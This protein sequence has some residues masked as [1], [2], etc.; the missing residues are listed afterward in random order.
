MGDDNFNI[1]NIVNID[2]VLFNND[3]DSEYSFD[4]LY[5]IS[6]KDSMKELDEELERQQEQERK[7]K[8]DYNTLKKVID[9]TL[10]TS[11]QEP[12]REPVQK[13]VQKPDSE[14][15]H[16]KPYSFR[17][18]LKRKNYFDDVDYSISTDDT[19][20]NN[21]EISLICSEDDGDWSDSCLTI[22]DEDDETSMYKR[23]KILKNELTQFT[24]KNSQLEGIKKKRLRNRFA[25]RVSRLKKK[26]T[27]LRNKK[28]LAHEINHN[29]KLKK[30]LNIMTKEKN[31]M[32]KRLQKYEP[33]SIFDE[34]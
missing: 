20:F 13:P 22:K 7:H 32:L 15:K 31:A 34:E 1:V 29:N 12:L 6:N 28:R 3:S 2:T 17:K 24:S 9:R 21:E 27:A 23:L 5:D 25:S 4:R 16:S 14:Q 8:H 30:Q 11:K 26:I 19:N 33:N 10:Y 18:R